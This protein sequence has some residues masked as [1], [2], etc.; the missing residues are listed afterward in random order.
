MS[1]PALTEA[2]AFELPPG[3]EATGPPEERGLTREAVRL[4]V[5]RR[6]LSIEHRIF[7]ELPSLLDPGDV[8]VVNTSATLPAALTARLRDGTPAIVHLSGRS[9]GGNW[10][11]ELRRPERRAT[12]PWLVAAAGTV[13][14]LPCGGQARLL[15]PASGSTPGAVRLWAASLALPLPVLAYLARH[16]RPIRY[17]YVT[18]NRPIGAYQT[19]FADE[20]GSAE[21][22]S[23][24]RPFSADLVTRLAA[25][26]VRMAPFV[27]H[28]GVSSPEAHEPPQTEWYRLPAP[29][30]ALINATRAEGRRVIA[31]G[32]T[33][34]RTL[35]T[36]AGPDGRVGAGEGWTDLVI[37]PARG[38]RAVDGL[39]T[40]WHEPQA[41]HLQLLEAVAGRPLLEASY[42]AALAGRYLWHE[43][44]DSH[45]I[46]R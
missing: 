8:L 35:E 4:L 30:A 38:V 39:I 21:M 45:L 23:A 31:V 28:A 10:V 37:T 3:L 27:L 40:G 16:G 7:S 15:A 42:T 43:F 32:T 11:L 34:V 46:L 29:S 41:S 2:L 17:G 33:A 5:A 13:L 44:G 26:G 25:R 24:A 1:A 18:A 14:E 9:R 22:P 19:V 36:V 20:P 6:D 12:V